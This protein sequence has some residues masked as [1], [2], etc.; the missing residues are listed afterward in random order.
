MS[1]KSRREYT[2]LPGKSS[3][4]KWYGIAIIF[5]IYAVSLCPESSHEWV[6]QC[7]HNGQGQLQGTTV[8]RL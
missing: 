6:V 5:H 3:G 4:I 7:S 2:V 8:L 1:Q